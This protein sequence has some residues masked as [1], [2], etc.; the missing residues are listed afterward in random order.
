ML[1]LKTKDIIKDLKK[2]EDMFDLSKL[3]ENHELFSNENKKVS[4]KFKIETPN[5][6][7]INEFVC[8]RSKM[9]AFKYGDGN[10]NK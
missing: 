6:I 5:S 10:K 1:S 7:W 2:L 8:L 3:N 4:G 9:Y